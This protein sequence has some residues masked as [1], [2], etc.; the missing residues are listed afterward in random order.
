MSNTWGDRNQDA[1]VCETF[2]AGELAHARRIG[3]GAVQIDDGWQKGKTANSKLAPG[4]GVWGEGYYAVMP[5]FWTP[6]PE[7]FPGGLASFREG[8]E[9]AGIRPGLW[10]SPDKTDGYAHWERD[11]ETLIGLH[12]QWGVRF[13]KLDG[14]T[15][16][17]KAADDRLY[18]LLRRVHE[19]T[20]GRV[21]FNLDITASRRWGYLYRRE[22]GTLFVEN[23]YTDWG[24]YYP[25]ATLRAAWLLCPYVPLSRLQLEFLN[26]RRN[27]EKYA[28]D[29]FAPS[30]YPIDWLFASVCFAN[31]LCWMEMS[32][33]APEDEERLAAIVAV[34]KPLSGELASA[35]VTRLG[36][37]PD[38]L[39]FTGL[40]ADFGDHGYLLL[41]RENGTESAADLV[42]PLQREGTL[43]TLYANGARVS[44]TD[45]GVRLET[46]GP[47]TFALARYESRR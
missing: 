32:S 38:G 37:E 45:G 39:A 1:A 33:L 35:D 42:C 36:G 15:I 43:R 24:N 46:D 14:I 3:V 7:K 19:A 20:D 2:M 18:A 26:P 13:F 9:A 41:F 28:G 17:S 25:H 4:S 5:D 10:F 29:P 30:L 44:R 16:E 31:P 11:A 22:F 6:A 23:R 40:R 21:T 8:A 12:R 27:A 34:W 47:R